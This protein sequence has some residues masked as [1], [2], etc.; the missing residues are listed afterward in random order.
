MFSYDYNSEICF[1]FSAC[2]SIDSCTTCITGPPTPDVS[3]CEATTSSPTP[4]PGGTRAIALGGK[5]RRDGLD[6]W[7]GST[8]L[9]SLSKTCPV[10]I[11]ELDDWGGMT[12]EFINGKVMACGGYDR[13]KA[14]YLNR[15]WALDLESD[16]WQRL[17]GT[18]PGSVYE[19]KSISFRSTMM[20]FGG[21]SNGV[22]NWVQ[23]YVIGNDTWHTRTDLYMPVSLQRH[24]VVNVDDELIFV[25]GGATSVSLD[26]AHALNYTSGKWTDLPSMHDARHDHTCL[27]WN[28]NGK[29]GILVVGGQCTGANCDVVGPLQSVE[30]FDF[31]KIRWETLYDSYLQEPRY[32]HGM[33]VLDG[34]PVVYGGQ[35]NATEILTS[36]ERLE[37]DTWV[38]VEDMLVTSRTDFAYTDIPAE[39]VDCY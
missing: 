26:S 31:E 10:N 11:W 20:I 33:S 37:V 2:K 17:E 1:L 16:E 30:F 3:N 32:A 19:G 27:L 15:C 9:F 23:E 7:L 6:Y 14:G 39:I 21:E 34:V 22:R 28:M 18:L 36:G 5:S 38:K 12:M 8:E 4:L 24:C 13:T 29:R 25:F 35:R